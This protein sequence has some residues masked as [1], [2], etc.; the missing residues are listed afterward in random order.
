MSERRGIDLRNHT[1]VVVTG[2]RPPVI[3]VGR[4]LAVTVAP[5]D[6]S[7]GD[8]SGV[9]SVSLAGRGCGEVASW[10]APRFGSLLIDHSGQASPAFHSA[11]DSLIQTHHDAWFVALED[12]VQDWR[13]RKRSLRRTTPRQR[14][15]WETRRLR[16]TGRSGDGLCGLGGRLRTPRWC[17]SAGRCRAVPG[18]CAGDPHGVRGGGG[19]R[20]GTSRTSTARGRPTASPSGSDRVHAR[21]GPRSTG[22]KGHTCHRRDLGLQRAEHRHGQD[23]HG[24]VRGRQY[25]TQRASEGSGAPARD[26]SVKDEPGL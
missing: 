12:A 16:P 20:S 3:E 14:M 9:R 13:R 2:D 26:P 24:T 1:V 23:E 7:A 11:S 25:E 4:P 15:G 21:G 22:R 10:S 6:D 17:S 18:G 8:G 19:R 5:I